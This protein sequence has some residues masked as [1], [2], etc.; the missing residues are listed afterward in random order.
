MLKRQKITYFLQNI[1][2]R[3]SFITWTTRFEHKLDSKYPIGVDLYYGKLLVVGKEEGSCVSHDTVTVS[4]VKRDYEIYT[5]KYTYYITR[6][7][8]Y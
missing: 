1:L 3:L 2:K 6:L 7:C 5:Y 8:I 4:I